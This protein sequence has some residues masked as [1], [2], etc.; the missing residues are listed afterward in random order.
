MNTFDFNSF[1]I[2]NAPHYLNGA[3]SAIFSMILQDQEFKTNLKLMVAQVELNNSYQLLSFPEIVSLISEFTLQNVL[4][5]GDKWHDLASVGW[6]MGILCHVYSNS[7]NVALNK[8][9]S[10]FISS[11]GEY[12]NREKI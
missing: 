4:N 2:D 6:Q 11:W 12:F 10:L 9:D 7:L 5:E 1:Y 3:K 8:F